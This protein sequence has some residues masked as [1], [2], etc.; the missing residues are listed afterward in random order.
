MPT[1]PSNAEPLKRKRRRFQFRLRTLM[2]AVS[3]LAVICSYVNRQYGIVQVR[4]RFIEERASCARTSFNGPEI[5]WVR[6]LLGDRGYTIIGLAED[7]DKTERQ[8][9]AA[10]FP[11]ARIFAVRFPHI[12]GAPLNSYGVLYTPFPDEPA[13]P[14]S[15]H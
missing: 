11:E 5:P 4:Q 3:L 13:W 9:T 15:D 1:E 10:L 8:R 6:S 12:P 14:Q 2:I 7:T